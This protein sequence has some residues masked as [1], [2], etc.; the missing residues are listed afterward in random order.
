MEEIFS[1]ASAK[2]KP[3]GYLSAICHIFPHEYGRCGLNQSCVVYLLTK[4]LNSY[5]WISDMVTIYIFSYLFHIISDI[6]SQNGIYDMILYQLKFWDRRYDIISHFGEKIISY[7]YLFSFEIW[8]M[9][10]VNVCDPGEFIYSSKPKK[11]WH[12]CLVC[13]GKIKYLSCWR[14][15]MNSIKLSTTR[16]NFG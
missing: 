2:H 14:G 6:I 1:S 4:V 15:A 3:G 5:V 16:F 12:C 10:W 8:S 9:S 11:V 13:L 7:L